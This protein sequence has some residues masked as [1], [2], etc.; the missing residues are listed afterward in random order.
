MNIIGI[1][2]SV[3]GWY[4]HKVFELI[5]PNRAILYEESIVA[6]VWVATIHKRAH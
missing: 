4:I 3:H 5:C 6:T 2:I 1:R